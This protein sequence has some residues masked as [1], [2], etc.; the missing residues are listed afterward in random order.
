MEEMDEEARLD[1][2]RREATR[3]LAHEFSRESDAGAPQENWLGQNTSS[4]YPMSTTLP[5]ETWSK[6]GYKSPGSR[7]RRESC[8]G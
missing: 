5:T 7:S 3:R 8:G 1:E 2:D 6:L 4:P